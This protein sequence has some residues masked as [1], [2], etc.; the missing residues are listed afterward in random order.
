MLLLLFYDFYLPGLSK[1][2]GSENNMEGKVTGVI[3]II[4]IRNIPGQKN[5]YAN[6]G[7]PEAMLSGHK[8]CS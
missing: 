4:Y 6:S 3:N 7:L 2:C 8:L 5:I 1:P